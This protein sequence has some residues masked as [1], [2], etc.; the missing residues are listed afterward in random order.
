[1]TSDW[2]RLTLGDIC[3]SY[4][5]LIQTGPFG[6]Q[7]HEYDYISEG[8]VPVVPTSAI[9]RRLIYADNLPLIPRAKADELARHYLQ[10]GDILFARRGVQATGL[11]A[12][13]TSKESGW[14]CGTGAILLRVPEG[15]VDP[16]YLSF[17][18]SSDETIS[19][20]KN[21][22]VGAVMP[23]L[24]EGILRRLPIELPPFHEQQCIA[25]LLGALDDKIEL[26]RAMSRTLEDMAQA[27]FK[28]WFI[29]F[30][31]HTDLVDSELGPI[32][33][34][35]KVV[36][37]GDIM[38]LKYGKSL[39]AKLRQEGTVPVYGSGGIGGY[40]NS[41]LVDGPGVVVGR[42]GSVG[43]VYWEEHDFFPIDTTFYVSSRRGH[44]W[45]YW[46]YHRLLVLDIHHLGADSAVPGVNR[47]AVHAQRC[48]EPTG[49]AV[50]E[51]ERV[52]QPLRQGIANNHAESQ[53]LA[54][55]R[56]TLLPKLI[57]GEIRIP[58]AEKAVEH[59]L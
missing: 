56:D 36:S 55:L 26:N 7:L 3:D 59:A 31:G 49:A 33:R 1:M 5:G 22:A 47:N 58:E 52:V 29:D 13:V 30:D 12:L 40:H 10:A 24:N 43:T 2:R 35:W 54:E 44:E 50:S 15:Y 17:Y 18:L 28:S 21:H 41:A 19:W 14:I 4:G 20:L 8:G 16:R 23:N 6:S 9:G 38:E 46:L 39:P 32:P 51:F 45:L 34:G 48:V 25:A 11:S 27:I 53:T 42:K 37:F 57:S